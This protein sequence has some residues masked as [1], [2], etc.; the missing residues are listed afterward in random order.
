MFYVTDLNGEKIAS[1]GQ[2]DSIRRSIL[3]VFE[4]QKEELAPK[5]GKR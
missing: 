1:A 5:A 4:P 3:K 2:Q